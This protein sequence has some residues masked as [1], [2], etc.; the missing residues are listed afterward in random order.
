MLRTL[1]LFLFAAVLPAQIRVLVWDEQQ[2]T[3]KQAYPNFLGNEIA[4]HL[5]SLPGLEVA[6]ARLDDPE[7]GL[8]AAALDKAQVLIWWGHVRHQEVPVEIG[9]QIVERILAGKLSLIAIHAAHWSVPF[10]EAMN[11]RTRQEAKKRYP[12]EKT[13]FEFVPPPGRVQPTSDSLVTP[14]FYALKKGKVAASVRVDLPLCVFPDVRADAKPSTITVL[15]PEHPIMRGVPR[16]FQI[17]QTEMYNEPFHIPTPDEV[18][19]EERWAGGE[20]FR[21]GMVWNLGKGKVFYFR[22]GHEIYPIFK[23]ELPLKILEN[24]VRWMGAQ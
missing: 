16:T 21:S 13:K 23:K 2:P 14:A 7:K 3:Q 22:P 5:K 4:A 19:F 8:S 11:E 20:W 12:D 6:S 17:P 9:R 24:A 15:K 1:A 10:M 18:V